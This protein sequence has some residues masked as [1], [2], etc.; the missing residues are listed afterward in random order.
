MNKE[1]YLSIIISFFNEEARIEDTIESVDRFMDSKDYKCELILS[2]DKSTDKSI[3]IA[4]KHAD[5]VEH[6]RY[7]EP[8]VHEPKGKGAGI[9]RGIAD[10]KGEYIMFMDADSS[11][12]IQEIEKLLPYIKDF[13]IV[14]GSRYIKSPR[15]YKP[16]YIAS[17]LHG[18]VSIFEVLI[19]GHSKDYQAKGKQSRF[20]QLVSRGRSAMRV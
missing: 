7:L 20:R 16:N 13:D 3:D 12:P 4:K 19:F 6:F 1:L 17:I 2:D 15:P 14:M 8:K 5:E 11:T 9:Q 18:I 10:A